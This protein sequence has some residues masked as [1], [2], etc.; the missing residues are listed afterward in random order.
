MAGIDT[1]ARERSTRSEHAER[2]LEGGLRVW[3]AEI[4]GLDAVDGVAELPS[5]GQAALRFLTGEAGLALPARRDRADQH[6]L[7]DMVAENAGT[8]LVNDADGFVADRQA[9]ADGIV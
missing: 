3:N 1:D 6:A 5:S 8:N 7:A 4:L 9:G 2:V